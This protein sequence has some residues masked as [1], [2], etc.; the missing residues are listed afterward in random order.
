MR[1]IA[2]DKKA[3]KS[4]DAK[5]CV[6]S[7]S[8]KCPV[9]DAWSIFESI[10]YIE[11]MTDI[12]GAFTGEYNG[13]KCWK[14][15]TE[16]WLSHA[17]CGKCSVKRKVK[18]KKFVTGQ[19][20]RSYSP[21]TNEDEYKLVSNL[22]NQDEYSAIIAVRK[23]EAGE[24]LKYTQQSE[25]RAIIGQGQIVISEMMCKTLELGW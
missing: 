8:F 22:R 6:V 3:N 23:R 24:I 16:K 11:R 20:N 2:M 10:E 25:S 4:P 13:E 9:C 5:E 7:L 19:G 12:P 14:A 15:N 21:W 17:L 1:A 18:V